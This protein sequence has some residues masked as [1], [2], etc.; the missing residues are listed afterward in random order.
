MIQLGYTSRAKRGLSAADVA[1]LVEK[2]RDFNAAHDITG[3]LL[4]HDGTFLHLLE[5]REE[6]VYALF[7]RKI[8]PDPRHANVRKLFEQPAMKRLF[9]EW[10]I[11]FRELT[12]TEA[13]EWQPLLG[14]LL[15][16]PARWLELFVR[17]K[18]SRRA[19]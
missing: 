2:A 18:G 5:G 8:A 19:A 12:A 4:F 3:M 11:A 17:F 6:M 10:P 7:S 9:G 14:N 13:S 16:D 1:A 15:T